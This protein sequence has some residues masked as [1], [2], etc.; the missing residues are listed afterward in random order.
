MVDEEPKTP[1]AE[2]D[3][4]GSDPSSLKGLTVA[5][6][7]EP[8]SVGQDPLLGRDIGGVTIVKLMAE[9]GMGRVYEGLQ[10]LPKRKVAVKVMRPGFISQQAG[11][12][13]G[14]ELEILGRLRHPFI[15][16]IYS[17]GMCDV[18]GSQV[19]FFIM[20]Y[21]PDALPLT[22]Y[23]REK[24][25]STQ[26]RI[27]L[28][29]KV[30]EAVAHGH[31]QG[32]VHRDLKPSNILV[33]ASGTPKIIDFGIARTIGDSPEKTTALT[34]IGQLIGTLQYMSPE[35]IAADPAAIDQRTDVYALGVILYELLTGA[36]PYEISSQQV[37]EAA[38]IVREH[39]PVSPLKL[40]RELSPGIVNVAGT[41]LQKDRKRR[42][43]D[44]AEVAS[45]VGLCLSPASQTSRKA[46]ADSSLWRGRSMKATPALV[47]SALG[48]LGLMLAFRQWAPTPRTFP[49]GT[50]FHQ[51]HAYLFPTKPTNQIEAA[52]AAKVAGGHLVVIDSRAENDF[53]ARNARG[54]TWIGVERGPKGWKR[55]SDGEPITFQAW[56]QGQPSNFA[57]EMPVSTNAKGVWH[58]H[59]MSDVL[60]Y[61]IEWG[62]A[63]S[64]KDRTAAGSNSA[65]AT[66]GP[67]IDPV[68]GRWQWSV[69]GGPFDRH[70]FLKDGKV[71]G[72][73]NASWSL[74][75]AQEQRYRF[76]WGDRFQDLMTL[77]T[78][79]MLL[80]GRNNQGTPIEG[81]KIVTQPAS[82]KPDAE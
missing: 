50:V 79:G 53:V 14:M 47:A 39:K 64:D 17:A 54:A 48:I 80:T 19:P 9:G 52:L 26:A 4:S 55:L 1:R 51:G 75:D 25:L 28:F 10:E 59:F 40:N 76:S 36:R 22:R 69:N 3:S 37:F 66:A 8:A 81:R 65:P 62:D 21:I 70:E 78:D 41:C 42:Y 12:R 20:E 13:F 32:I 45:A 6:G 73:P 63:P 60:H 68:M 46:A 2:T 49:P 11:Y 7:I 34:E 77:S 74:I 33:E 67:P 38:R 57:G 24:M 15:A 18:V 29:Q 31:S 58:D 72:Y 43:A 82:A 44:A 61:C 30:C 16:Q 71:R 5:L 35:Q 27:A 23:C 56:D